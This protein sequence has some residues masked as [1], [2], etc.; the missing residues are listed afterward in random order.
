M[1]QG[2]IAVSLVNYLIASRAGL[3][4]WKTRIDWVALAIDNWDIV[5]FTSLPLTRQCK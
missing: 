2:V 5:N 3:P 1:M 4:P